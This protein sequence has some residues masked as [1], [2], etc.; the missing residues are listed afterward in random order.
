VVAIAIL[1]GL[2]YL[3][4]TWLGAERSIDK[5]RI[6]IAAVQRGTLVRDV[7]ADGRVVAANSPTLYAIAPG[8]VDF[9]VRAGD[10]VTRDQPLA[11]VAS[12]ELQSRLTQEQAT[13]AGLDA[14]SVAVA[15][16]SSTA[17]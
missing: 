9:H 6:R 12:P 8:T 2:G 3:I 17:T 14:A 10:T 11:T 7:V 15:S 13:L 1:A 16:M 5:S 4:R